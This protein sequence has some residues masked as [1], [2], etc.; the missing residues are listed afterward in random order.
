MSSSRSSFIAANFP[1]TVAIICWISAT[2]GLSEQGTLQAIRRRPS[3]SKLEKNRL[4]QN[5]RKKCNAIRKSGPLTFES[6]K[7]L[8]C[9]FFSKASLENIDTGAYNFE[10]SYESAGHSHTLQHHPYITQTVSGL[11]GTARAAD[12]AALRSR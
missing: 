9:R 6:R 10:A 11:H 3:S 8:P 2:L 5:I 1:F 4:A 12:L 7:T